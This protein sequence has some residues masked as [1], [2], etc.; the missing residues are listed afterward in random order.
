MSAFK[1]PLCGADTN[2]AV[3]IDHQ[4]YTVDVDYVCGSCFNKLSG[5][6][7]K[8]SAAI[9][10]CDSFTPYYDNQLEAF[11]ESK[12][13]KASLL[14]QLGLRQVSGPPSPKKSGREGQILSKGQS[15]TYARYRNSIRSK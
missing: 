12:E 11:V 15:E 6:S 10:G 3:F 13:H 14:N 1:C 9:H 8:E 4:R 7:T 2:H 5:R